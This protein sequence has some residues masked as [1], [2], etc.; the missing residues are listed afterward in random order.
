MYVRRVSVV[1]EQR[2]AVGA[3]PA[4]AF[5]FLHDPERRQD[6]DA[7]VDGCRLEGDAPAAGARLHLHGRRKAPSWV[8]E[9]AE[10]DAPRRSVLRLVGGVG[11][12]FSAFSQTITVTRHDPTTSVVALRIEYAARGPV[13][14]VERFTL[15]PRLAGAVRRSVANIAREL[16]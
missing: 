10:F 8:G 2:T 15:R 7:M 14:L 4:E 11:M 16:G 6:W 1:I 3:K 13:V 9:Y 12:P 5:A